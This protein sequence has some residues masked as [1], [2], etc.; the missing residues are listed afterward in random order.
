MSKTDMNNNCKNNYKMGDT[1]I[2]KVD[3]YQNRS[4][5]GELVWANEKKS[6]RFRSTLEMLRLMDEAI[7]SGNNM[8]GMKTVHTVS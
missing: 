3:H 6:V 7:K 5:Q 8:S 4:W 2:I 1:F